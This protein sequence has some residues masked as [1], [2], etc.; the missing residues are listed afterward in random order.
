M[1]ITRREATEL[2]N[3]HGLAPSRALGQ[4][5]VV[6]ANTVRRIATLAD[7]GPGDHVVEIGAGLGS[8]TRALLETGASV[9]AIEVDRG[10]VPILRELEAE[11]PGKLTVVEADA[12]KADW[13]TL[14]AGYDEWKLI[15]NLPY[16]VATP[17]VADILD[18]VPQVVSMLVMVQYEVG[19]RMVAAA[20]TAAYGALSVKISYWATAKIV[21]SVSPQVFL[22]R[23]KVNSALVR[24]D[25][26]S[27]PAVDADPAQLFN[28]VRTGFGQRRKMLRRS[29][30]GIV[31]D[32]QFKV[33][34]VA[35][36]A[37]PEELDVEAWGRLCQALN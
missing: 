22:P 13:T 14:L 10:L 1:T 36:E 8:L 30:A 12:T 19:E 27:K 17:L 6:D 37:R 32:A 3:S 9:M 26:R 29:L 35:P 2:L 16:N 7:V 20:R 31:S 24:I 25:R 5:F 28:L 11:H 21:G 15:A 34:N 23:P 4:N 18:G 33:A